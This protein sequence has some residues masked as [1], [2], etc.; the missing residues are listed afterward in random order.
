MISL[1]SPNI[2]P[3]PRSGGNPTLDRRTRVIA[4]LEEQKLLLNDSTYM[5]SVRSWS[6]DA[7]GTKVL[8]KTKQ[9][10]LPWWSAQPNGSLVFFIRSGWKPIEFE[11]GKAAIAVPSLEKL[12]SVIDTMITAVRNGELDEQL[13]Q[14]S[15]EA[16]PPKSKNKRAA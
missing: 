5:R 11:K 3:L 4:R 1:K 15:S 9:R 12:P 13:A 16:K 6:K 14:A 7:D 8:V 10:V 2:I